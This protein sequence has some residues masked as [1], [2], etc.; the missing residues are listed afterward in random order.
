MMMNWHIVTS[1]E[2]AAGVKRESSL[3]FISDTHE[4]YRGEVPFTES[5]IMYTE[6]PVTGIAVNRLYI[7]SA[8]LEG[9]VYDG[10]SWTTV[11]RPITD[12]VTADGVNPVSGK[13]VAAYVAAEVAKISASGEVVSALTWDSAEHLL[14]VTK[15]NGDVQNIIFE[16]LGVN[17]TYKAASGELQLEDAKGTAIGDAIKLDLERFVSSG[18]Y[19]AETSSIILYFDAEKTESVTIPV[20]ELVDTYTAEGDKAIDLKVES[21]VVKGSIKISTESGNTIIVKDDGLYVAATDISGKM[22]KVADGVEGNILVLDADGNAADSGKSFD[23]IVPNNKVYI[24]TTF[25]E[26]VTG[27]TP[28]KNDVVVVRSK[29]GETDKYQRVAYIYDGETWIP[30]DEN[31]S[32]DNVYFSSDLVTTAAIGNVTLTNGQ[33]TIA[34]AGKS[35]KQVWDSIFIQEKNPKITQPSVSLT[36]KANGTTITSTATTYDFE[37]GTTVTPS[38]SATLN[39]GKYEFN[40]NN[41]ATGIT[42]S[43][44]EISDTDGHTASTNSGSFDSFVVEDGESYKI[45]AKANYDASTITPVTNTGNDYTAGIIGAGSKSSTQ[46]YAIQAHR[47]C[48]YGTTTDK[49]E[50]TSDVIRSLVG[51]STGAVAAGTNFNIT[52]PVGAMRVIFAYPATISAATSVKDGNASDAQILSSFKTTTIDVEGVD[53]YDAI[54]YRVYYM[55]RAE[56][57]TKENTYKVTI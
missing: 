11:I 44:W 29:I 38:Y 50:I 7:N 8:T 40:E 51:K 36:V 35:L 45:T 53:G 18:E 31:Y 16:G 21:N 15:G 49:A 1:A 25:D 57:N 17:L 5:V 37:A 39:P 43:S 22:D 14:A 56:A 20:G 34:A 4:I 19:D 48:F 52:V 24:G 28:V 2:Y 23:D 46:T 10:T 32:A 30:M 33:A 26:A 6:L 42:A 47:K 13:A 55:E 54:S 41:G 3:Y 9:K 12:T 27:V